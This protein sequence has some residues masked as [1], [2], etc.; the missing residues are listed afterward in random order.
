MGFCGV[1]SRTLG[2]FTPC[3]S[4]SKPIV[5]LRGKKSQGKVSR[6]TESQG[7]VPRGKKSLHQFNWVGNITPAHQKN[8][9][10]IL[11]LLLLLIPSETFTKLVSYVLVMYYVLFIMYCVF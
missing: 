2:L 3:H 7:K 8:A 4:I 10:V 5:I 6:G 11:I 9:D 1:K